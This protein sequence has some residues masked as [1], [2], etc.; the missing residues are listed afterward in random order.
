MQTPP[1]VFSDYQNRLSGTVRTIVQIQIAATYWYVCDGNSGMWLSGSYVY[2]YLQSISGI[3]DGFDIYS[4]RFKVSDVTVKISNIPYKKDD[5]P[6]AWLRLSDDL[7]NLG[8]N[9]VLKV[10][11][12]AGERATTFA[13]VLTRFVGVVKEPPIH[14]GD[15]IKIRAIDTGKYRDA[16]IPTTVVS[17][18]FS[19]APKEAANQLIPIVYGSFTAGIDELDGTGLALAL[20]TAIDLHYYGPRPEV[21]VSDHILNAFTNLWLKIDSLTDLCVY[22]GNTMTVDDSGRGT[23]TDNDEAYAY[24]YPTHRS[25]V[26]LG[27]SGTGYLR[28]FDFVA[29]VDHYKAY[30]RD[31]ST[32]FVSDDQAD[33]IDVTTFVVFGFEDY[34]TGRAEYANDGNPIGILSGIGY[35]DLIAAAHSGITFDKVKKVFIYY[36]YDSTD[37]SLDLG[38]FTESIS[39]WQSVEFGMATVLDTGNFRRNI[40]WHLKSGTDERAS[41][42]RGPFLVAIMGQQDAPIDGGG[43][44]NN[45]DMCDVRQLRM[46]FR[47]F[48]ARQ[49]ALFAECEG[50][51]YDSWITGRSSNY[52]DGDT[53]E[54]P[55]GIIESLLRDELGFVDADIDLPS[56]IDAENTSTKARI[57]FHSD[58]RMTV[59]EAIR[60]IAEQSTFSFAWTATGQARLIPLND[61]TPT[62]NRIIP[63]SHINDKIT[64]TKTNIIVN[65]MDVQSRFAQEY[66]QYMDRESKTNATSDTTYGTRSYT[67]EWPNISGSSMDHVTEH[68]VTNADGIW[69]NEHLV[70][71]FEAVLFTNADLEIGDWIELSSDVDPHIKA[72]GA[73]WS[74]K[75]FLVVGLRQGMYST[76]ITAIEL[77]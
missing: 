24:I 29:Q 48:P 50:R 64:I 8:Q 62:T 9:G 37:L 41:S 73:S 58:N 3:V 5:G 70:I 54:D 16:T 45:D 22:L 13:D 26:D 56:F 23:G 61:S 31:L 35:I 12:V 75:Q 27:E 60:Q 7:G 63:W 43:V 68:L 69:A 42:F 32:I 74:G 49:D 19:A 21:V 38:T 65:D 4:K 15:E 25:S 34:A 39:A 28:L 40:A 14:T 76:K 10:Y 47:F 20:T 44:T 57:N 66:N 77:Y 46:R 71:E 36:D 30:D 11:L 33:D 17:S 52:S 72:F 51:E 2:P 59:F 18:V 53:I 55:A 67:A 1:A 6:D